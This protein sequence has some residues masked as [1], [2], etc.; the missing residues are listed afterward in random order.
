VTL[1]DQ[2]PLVL[3]VTGAPASGKTTLGRQLASALGLPYFSKDLFKESLFDSLGWHD[4]AWSQRLGGAS[5]R[6]LFRS[7]EALLEAGQ[8]VLIECNFYPQWDT[9]QLHALRDRFACSFVQVVCTADGP[10]L[11]ERYEKRALS[12]ERH[13]GHT[14]ARSLAEL[15]P[16][17]LNERWEALDLD[18]P[19]LTVDTTNTPVDIDGLVRSI[20]SLSGGRRS[21]TGP[22]TCFADRPG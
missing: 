17:L 12:G 3:I 14:D 8:S 6:L 4:R 13:P 21:V 9:P 19:V 5:T 15:L 7:A 10:T 2:P 1:R 20:R 16:R 18:A 11:V 22:D